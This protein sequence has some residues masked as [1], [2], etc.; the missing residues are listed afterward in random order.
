MTD[1]FTKLCTQFLDNHVLGRIAQYVVENID[2][3]AEIDTLVTQ[4]RECLALPELSPT[5]GTLADMT[6]AVN[7]RAMATLKGVGSGV[8]PAKGKGRKAASSAPASEQKRIPAADYV[9]AYHRGEQICGYC[10]MRE[11]PDKTVCGQPAE[12]E[13][14]YGDEI[15]GLRCKA[16]QRNKGVV[17]SI[18][19]GVGASTTT[20]KTVS[21]FNKVGTKAPAG[22][23]SLKPGIGAPAG[24]SS[25]K[26]TKLRGMDTLKEDHLVGSKEMSS[27]LFKRLG[28]KKFLCLGK[29]P[30]DVDDE[31]AFDEGYEEDVIPLTEEEVELCRETF[32]KDSYE[33]EIAAPSRT[34]AIEPATMPKVQPKT[35]SSAIGK[36]QG[37]PIGMPGNMKAPAG[38][39]APTIRGLSGIRGLLR[40]TDAPANGGA[41]KKTP[42][43][44]EDEE[45]EDEDLEAT[46]TE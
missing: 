23:K 27:F 7:N 46:G 31:Y 26:K 16:H 25:T 14:E 35:T 13:T 42:K 29:F 18:L 21:G 24:K 44:E 41:G 9:E 32:G 4:F 43:K 11:N 19:G 40:P 22:V 34:A 15:S 3:G 17:A 2:T 30:Y 8:A 12:I 6:P 1:G 10:P 38:V 20:S 36:I 37:A 39:K 28:E 33:G 5:S 45:D